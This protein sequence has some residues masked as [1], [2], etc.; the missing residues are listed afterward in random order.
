VKTMDCGLI[1][2][3]FRGFFAKCQ[4]ILN[5]GFS[6]LFHNG[7]VHGL[8]PRFVDDG[9]GPSMVD[10]DG[11]ADGKPLEGGRDDSCQC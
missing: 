4:E 11:N 2:K 1:I 3:K 7:T 6:D 5:F 10:P 8:G 9:L